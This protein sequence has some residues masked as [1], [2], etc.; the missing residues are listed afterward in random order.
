M[1]FITKE[2]VYFVNN[3]LY[4]LVDAFEAEDKSIIVQGFSGHPLSISLAE[5]PDPSEANSGFSPFEGNLK[6]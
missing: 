2:E 3:Y 1:C 4:L 6:R 5:I